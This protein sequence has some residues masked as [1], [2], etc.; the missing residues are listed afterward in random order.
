MYPHQ[1]K[2]RRSFT[3]RQLELMDLVARGL[4]NKEIAG[5]LAISEQAV[6]EQISALLLRLKVRNR[7]ALAE[8]GARAA[9]VGDVTTSR[10]WLPFHFRYSPIAIAFLRGP[11][12]ILEAVNDAWREGAGERD[13]IGVSL[14]DAYPDMSPDIA[15]LIDDAYADGRGRTLTNAR[16]GWRSAV[17]SD[18]AGTM[19][20]VVQP[21]PATRS[22]AGVLMFLLELDAAQG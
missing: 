15:S 21:V 13:P 9:I 12:H 10:E 20:V 6:K 11:D 17:D 1:P 8:V 22:A 14:R 3:S 19:T 16:V 7:A 2:A 4:P 5:H 18:E